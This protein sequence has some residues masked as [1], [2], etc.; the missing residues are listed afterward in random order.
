[1]LPSSDRDAANAS[2]NPEVPVAESIPDRGEK[3]NGRSQENAALTVESET[4]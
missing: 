3:R 1:M 2:S 4:S